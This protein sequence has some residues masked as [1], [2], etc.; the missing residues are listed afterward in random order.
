MVLANDITAAKQAQEA[1][2]KSAANLRAIFEQSAQAFLLLDP[3]CRILAFNKTADRYLR[4]IFGRG[5]SVSDSLLDSISVHTR[6][7]FLDHVT[8]ALRG[9]QVSTERRVVTASGEKLWFTFQHTPVCNEQGQA[10]A[11]FFTALDITARKRAEE[12]LRQSEARFQRIAANFPGGMI[13]QFLLRPDGSIALPYVSPNARDLYEMEPEEIQRGA[14]LGFGLVHREDRAAFE[15]S[16]AHSAQTLS[17]WSWEFRIIT[18]S[19][20]LKWLRGVSR[21]EKQAN[22]DILWDGLLTD[23]TERK[24]MEDALLQA[25][26]AAEVANRA[27]S[28]FLATMSHELRTPLNA[29]LG[30]TQLFLSD[31]F[32]SLTADQLYGLRRVDDNAQALLDLI[33]SVLDLSRLEEGRLPLDLRETQVGAVLQEVQA[34]TRGLQEQTP[35]QFV[36][37]SEAALPVLYTDPGKLKIVLKNLVGNAVKFT[38]SGSITVAARGAEGGVEFRVTDTGIG[39]PPEALGAIFE[40][41]RQLEHAVTR[42]NG[43]TG[44]GLH[45]VQ[46][47]LEM[48]GGTITVESEVGQGSTFRVW[49]PYASTLTAR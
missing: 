46:R 42:Q 40:P 4:T 5:L 37:E 14:T 11:V 49:L 17:P 6:G 45:I 16:I 41:F 13:F 9:G 38:P 1:L 43:G 15:R 24:R 19:G 39:I 29:V 28:E 44:L 25:K 32:G 30:Y 12:A 2:K 35:L 34:E 27:K 22:G 20:T 33:S 26:E 21:P 23:V 31:A 3:Q 48:L 18:K 47:L 36:W 8:Q 10:T 7:E